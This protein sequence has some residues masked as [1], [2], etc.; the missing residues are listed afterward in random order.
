MQTLLDSQIGAIN[1]LSPLKVGALLK[2][3]GTGKSRTAIELIRSVKNIEQVI[4]LAPYRSVNPKIE[5]SGIKDEVNKWGGFE[6]PVYF[7]GIESLS[8]SDRIYLELRKLIESRNTF[9]VCDESLKIKNYEAKRTNR[10]IEAGKLCEYKLILNGTPISRNLLDLKPQ[11]DFLS[12]RILNMS[13]PQYKDTFCEYVTITK[14]VGHS[15]YKREFISKYH[16]IDYLYSLIRPYVYEAD[17]QLSVGQQHIDV[18]YEI[19]PEMRDEYEY[20]KVKY[21]DDDKLQAMNNNIFIEMTMKMQHIYSCAPE[22]FTMAEKIV[23]QHKPENVVIFCKF[24]DSRLACEKYF[25]GIPVLS[26]QSDSS[27]I[28]LQSKNV[29][30]EWD[31]TWDY[32]LVDQYRFRTYRIGQKKTCYH[33][34]LNA[35]T[36]LDGLM[37]ANNDKKEDQLEYFKGITKKELKELL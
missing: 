28:N 9:M 13:N 22:K 20:L 15:Y 6:I 27:S 17:L 30:I 11:I 3:P 24:I 23:E 19:E 29:T 34:Y 36:K 35:N 31:K 12:P 14:H 18:C 5:G 16:N 1:K 32:A 25:K 2:R 8:N 4:W 33:Y 21:L 7:I 26:I 37:K 10:V